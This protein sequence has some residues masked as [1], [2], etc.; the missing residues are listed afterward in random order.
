MTSRCSS[1][2]YQGHKNA[3]AASIVTAATALQ[4]ADLLLQQVHQ[5]WP[6]VNLCAKHYIA[7]A[8]KDLTEA[9]TLQDTAHLMLQV[10]WQQLMW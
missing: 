10:H 7:A 4:D 6:T 5:Q 8:A 1:S 2:S 3:D 9:T